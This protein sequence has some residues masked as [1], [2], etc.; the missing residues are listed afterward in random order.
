[1]FHSYSQLLVPLKCTDEMMK[2][3]TNVTTNQLPEQEYN[4]AE[5]NMIVH[6]IMNIMEK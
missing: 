3:S 6:L 1:M 2:K 5:V 4:Y